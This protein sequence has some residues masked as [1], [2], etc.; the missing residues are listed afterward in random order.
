MNREQPGRSF[1]GCSSFAI[2]GLA[3]RS[4]RGQIARHEN[5][6][7]DLDYRRDYLLLTPVGGAVFFTLN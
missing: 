1:P 2:A 6:P 5:R 4:V 7:G 3:F